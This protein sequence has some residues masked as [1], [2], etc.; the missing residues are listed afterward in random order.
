M[1]KGGASKKFLIL[2]LLIFIISAF[3]L[4][5]LFLKK[6]AGSIF[7]GTIISLSKDN[8]FTSILVDGSFSNINQETPSETVISYSITDT[9]KIIVN[10]SQGTVEE[11]AVGNF[12]EIKGP[13][14]FRTSY[15]AQGDAD[16]VT[17]LAEISPEILIKGE[18]IEV[19]I[20]DDSNGISFLVKGEVTG[21]GNDSEVYV[22]VPEDA[23]FTQGTDS[24]FIPGNQ[25]IVI[26]DGA[27]AESYPMQGTASSVILAKQK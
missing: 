3:S 12:V 14:T 25:V 19:S 20:E 27:L 2:A 1:E 6:E 26:I 21:Y 8:E 16:E 15:P 11:L 5:Q 17:L 7:E 23:Y 18:I 10:Q 9:T 24:I 13:D 4:Y 22:R